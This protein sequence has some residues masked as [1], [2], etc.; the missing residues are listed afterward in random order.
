MGPIDA[1]WHVLNFFGPAI[2]V[3]LIAPSMAKL[4]WRRRLKQASWRVL[5]AW[6]TAACAAVLV[7]GLVVFGHDGKMAT[8]AAVVAASALVLWW[9]GFAS[10]P[11]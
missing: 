5:V 9:R 2:G 11:A 7:A 10:R 3:G 1:F 8:Y 4:L 6:V